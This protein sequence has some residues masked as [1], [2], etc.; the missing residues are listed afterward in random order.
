MEGR[1]AARAAGRIR[2]ERLLLVRLPAAAPIET[3]NGMV[4][5]NVPEDAGRTRLEREP[6]ELVSGRHK[7]A[8]ALGVDLLVNGA[9]GDRHSA[10]HARRQ[11]ANG[12]WGILPPA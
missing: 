1:V 7:Q 9:G 6:S 11:T 4:A 2:A 10:E 3:L 12:Q 5:L 8:G